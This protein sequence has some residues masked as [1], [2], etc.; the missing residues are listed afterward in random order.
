M[1]R[2]KDIFEGVNLKLIKKINRDIKISTK[3]IISL[4]LLCIIP[5]SIVGYYTYNH[6]KSTIKDK[7]GNFSSELINQMAINFDTKLGHIEKLSSSI[8]TNNDLMEVLSIA[9][10]DEDVSQRLKNQQVIKDTF[11]SI[12][13]TDE[14]IDSILIY[15]FNN[16]DTGIGTLNTGSLKGVLG[17]NLEETEVFK[18]V[19]EKDGT[20][21][22]IK[23]SNPNN[24]KIDYFLLLRSIKH[25]SLRT[26]TKEIGVLIF[27][28][29]TNYADNIVSNIKMDQ[30]LSMY[31]FNNDKEILY[32]NVF[33]PEQDENEELAGDL[34][35][36]SILNGEVLLERQG[37]NIFSAEDKRYFT[38]QGQ[39]LASEKLRN[40]WV[41]TTAIPLSS[42]TEE[43]DDLKID[44]MILMLISILLCVL[45]S[46]L[47]SLS[48][49][50]PLKTI[51][52]VMQRTKKGDLTAKSPI[53]GNNEFGILSIAFNDMIDN[54]KV[55]IEKT[56]NTGKDVRESTAVV[57]DVSMET[58]SSTQ[59]VSSA[60]E[61]IA[62][63]AAEQSQEA[64]NSIAAMNQLADRI[65]TASQK[66]AV[67]VNTTNKV[68][69]EGENASLT[70][71][72]LN[73]KTEETVKVSTLIKEDI[74]NLNNNIEE[75]VSIISVINEIAE[76]INLLSL[77][78]SIEAAR[79][80]E[81]GRGF[82]VVAQEVR[83][84]AEEANE[85]TNNI[86]GIIKNIFSKTRNTVQEVNKADQIFKEQQSSVH[87]TENAF[88]NILAAQERILENINFITKVIGE[89]TEDKEKTVKQ[90]NEMAAIAEESAA[91]T[92]EVS[93]ISQEQSNLAEKLAD[94]AIKLE[95]TVDSLNGV[96]DEFII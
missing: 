10:E 66:I 2:K 14:D 3:L 36:K 45:L 73:Q 55:L 26:G 35:K 63:G 92:E 56:R 9:N 7:A 49:S 90:I 69:E 81:N 71:K 21:V 48:V 12:A 61:E 72:E 52:N 84:L 57:K 1:K 96:L 32:Q 79:A 15:R 31:L 25:F 68:K 76:Q 19:M 18:E 51:V 22:W 65:N 50:R 16:R 83:K 42:L 24:Q 75:I 87:D 58:I 67:I 46:V 54:I 8:I 39:L 95:E 64:Q 88:N 33:S 86:E 94:L 70:I 4:L 53:E 62:N 43:I 85:A 5:L 13:F 80:G 29:R 38:F 93:A 91:S 41:L 78:A 30:E 37:A 23:I 82:A 11:N 89:V 27:A 34:S 40:G 47:I 44:F 60:I 28:L 6:S 17:N 20:P 74:E 59:Q 77:N